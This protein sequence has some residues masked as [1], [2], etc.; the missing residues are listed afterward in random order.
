MT[1]TLIL[2]GGFGGLACARSL[3]ARLP[4]AHRIVVVDRS[5]RFVVGAT[6]TWIM[7]DRMSEEEAGRPRGA[8]LPERV[9]L[10]ASEV[11]AIDPSRREVEITSGTISADH[12]VLALGAE[13]DMDAVPGLAD[14][15]MTFYTLSGAARLREALARFRGG[16][17]MLLIPRTPFQ[18]PPAPYEATLL[19]HAML[20]DRG[21]RAATDLGVWTLELAP[22]QTAGPTMGK[23]VVD[24][25]RSRGIGFNPGKKTTS[26]DG[27][28]RTVR[29]EDGDEAPYDLLIAI[30]PHRAPRV[31]VAAGLAETLGWVAVDPGTFE[32]RSAAAPRHVY[33]VG[34]ATSVPL[35]GRFDPAV[36]LALP[37]AGV[38][39]AAAGEAVAGR[40]AA[41]VLGEGVASAFDG[42][43]FCFIEVGGG[44]A[45]RADG[46][47]FET[48]SPVMTAQPADEAQYRDKVAWISR[49]QA[50]IR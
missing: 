38:F 31:L 13:L 14:T 17:L 21:L 22:M 45:M 8:L 16:R 19:L 23:R 1:T 49:W 27:A 9:E 24:E 40:I 3:R 10:V 29:F 34:D 42:R 37:K 46:A 44:R 30:P 48:P 25:L 32:V 6:K 2:G 11:L 35:P 7:L 41:K 36:P 33:A 43:G 47:F 12:L 39:A 18:C 20:E 4:E 26:V 50:A 15:A 5:P 28:R